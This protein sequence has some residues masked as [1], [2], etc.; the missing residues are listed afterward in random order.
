MSTEAGEETLLCFG[1]M[2]RKGAFY[3]ANPENEMCKSDGSRYQS[4]DESGSNV[5]T[6]TVHLSCAQIP[7]FAYIRK[8]VL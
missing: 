5:R 8:F 7:A 3:K 6:A 2:H 1:V 4:F